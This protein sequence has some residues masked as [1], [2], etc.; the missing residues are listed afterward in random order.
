M[1]K[2]NKN[3]ISFSLGI[4]AILAF[5]VITM[6]LEAN[7][8]VAGYYNRY[9][10]PK[11]NQT[12]YILSDNVSGIPNPGAPAPVDYSPTPII[13]SNSPTPTST[14]TVTKVVKSKSTSTATNS[15]ASDLAANA[16]FGSNGFMPSGLIQWILFA[17]FILLIVILVRKVTG[18]ENKYHEEP[19]KHA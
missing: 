3:L 1:K 2:M 7:A 9:N 14:N 4:L 6:P 15:D 5:G 10:K 12:K 13:Y 11:L 8:E 19:M 18:T 17:I 16:I